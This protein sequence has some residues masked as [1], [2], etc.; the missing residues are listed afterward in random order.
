MKSVQASEGSSGSTR[1]SLLA[2]AQAQNTEAWCELVELYGPLVA[3]WCRNRQLDSHAT[4]DIVQEVFSSVV[5]ALEHFDSRSG[6]SAAHSGSFRG[7]LW[8]ITA[9]KIRDAARRELR[10][11]NGKGGSTALQHLNELPDGFSLPD[12]EPTSAVEHQM[13]IRRAME[14]VR[15][16]FEP[17]TWE[18]FQR[19]FVDHVPTAVVATEFQ[20]TPAAIRQIRSR[21]LR[22]IRQQLGD[23]WE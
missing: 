4:A 8:T 16:E 3:H 20:R 17:L 22:R 13:L 18:I 12:A 7:W 9:N 14:Q 19:S 23:L 5:R 1:A 10:Q 11:T 6:D 21:V 2:R 15:C